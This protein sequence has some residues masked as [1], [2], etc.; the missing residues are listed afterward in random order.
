MLL[1]K[2]VATSRVPPSRC[3]GRPRSIYRHFASLDSSFLAS[4]RCSSSVGSVFFT[5]ACPWQVPRRRPPSR[6][7]RR[8]SCRPPGRR[9]PG[10]MHK[11][12]EKFEPQSADRD[13]NHDFMEQ[14]YQ[15]SSC[16]FPGAL[17]SMW[18]MTFHHRTRDGNA[19]PPRNTLCVQLV[20]YDSS[21]EFNHD[22]L[23]SITSRSTCL[24]RRC[25]S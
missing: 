9:S 1:G 12:K 8:R 4:A 20:A 5:R 7:R 19:V 16:K 23:L 25:W 6:S 10:L 18:G 17:S 3:G 24:T 2:R 13:F 21:R 11:G 15:Q 14:G 22:F